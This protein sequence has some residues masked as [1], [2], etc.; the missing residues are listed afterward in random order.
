MTLELYY[1]FKEWSEKIGL[2]DTNQNLLEFLDAFHLLNAKRINKFF[3]DWS[4]I[5]GDSEENS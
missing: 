1:C 5:I 4:K 3:K 2:E